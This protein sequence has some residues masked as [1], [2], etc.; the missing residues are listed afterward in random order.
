MRLDKPKN[1][2]AKAIKILYL[3]YITGVSMAV[4]LTRHEPCFYKFQ[5]RL[6][7]VHRAH[8]TLKVFHSERNYKSKMDGKTRTYMQYIPLS[9]KKYLYNLFNKINRQGLKR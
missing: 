4:V 7:E 1:D 9:P 5:S 2:W 3:N 6:G 8:P